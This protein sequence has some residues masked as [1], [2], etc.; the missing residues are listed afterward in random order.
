ML[1]TLKLAETVRKVTVIDVIS[2]SDQLFPQYN[3]DVPEELTN[4]ETEVFVRVRVIPKKP[5]ISQAKIYILV[6]V[7]DAQLGVVTVDGVL[8][9]VFM[10][11]FSI[12]LSSA[13]FKQNHSTFSYF[14]LKSHSLSRLQV[15]DLRLV[16]VPNG[17]LSLPKDFKKE[18]FSDQYVSPELLAKLKDDS[19]DFWQ[20]AAKEQRPIG[21]LQIFK[22][23]SEQKSTRVEQG[24]V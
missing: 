4:R 7:N 13:F 21:E 24:V 17:K 6:R 3:S 19:E 18:E 12:D 5:T 10:P 20:V 9:V 1:I 23:G 11:P 22:H 15:S 14:W 2:S 8:T 16:D